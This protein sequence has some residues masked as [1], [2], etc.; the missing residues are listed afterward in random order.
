MNND[1]PEH[2]FA[3]IGTGAIGGYYGA[4]LQ[5]GGNTVHFLLRSDYDHVK[6]QGLIIESVAGN[7]ILETVNAHFS[8][9]TIPPCDVVLVTLKTTGNSILPEILPR[10]VKKNGVVIIMQNGL[11]VEDNVAE[12]TGPEQVMGGLCFIC[13]AKEGPGHIRHLD[14]GYITLGDYSPDIAGAGISPRMDTIAQIFEN[15]GITIYR[16]GNLGLARWKKLV[17]NIPFNGLSVVL[18]ATTKELVNN[19]DSHALVITLMEEV[20]TG[21]A[22][23]GYEI[24]PEI[25]DQMIGSTESMI[26]YRPS[27]KIDFDEKRPMEIESIYAKPLD[28]AREHSQYMPSIAALHKELSFLELRNR[29]S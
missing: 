15:A 4:M 19:S 13:A 7:F 26:P 20:I 27:M 8:P 6:N 12:M 24:G 16:T 17:W 10:I 29:E 18:N 23:C 14:Y 21:A 25:I 5:R 3:V 9:D 1:H 28:I 2:T 22:S 11:G